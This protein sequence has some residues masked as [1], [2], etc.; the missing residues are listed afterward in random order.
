MVLR[1]LTLCLWVDVKRGSSG[2]RVSNAVLSNTLKLAVISTRFGRLNAKY[3]HSA[4]L[5]R[6]HCVPA[7]EHSE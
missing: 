7:D 2:R 5:H 1:G 3:R 6:H 4:L